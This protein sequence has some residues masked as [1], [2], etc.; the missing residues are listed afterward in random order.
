MNSS[1][2]KSVI[3]TLLL[4]GVA[5]PHATWAKQAQEDVRGA[6]TSAAPAAQREAI[7]SAA[8][9]T[10]RHITR[11]RSAI[12]NNDLDQA[13]QDVQQARELLSLVEAARPAA[14]LKE[15][16]WVVRQ[17]MDYE[18]AED[19]IDDLT[20]IDAE[21]LSL[22][23]IMPTA[24]AHRHLQ[25]VQTLM[26]KN[27]TE[28][29]RQELDRLEASLVFTEFDLPLA[30]C[31][32]QILAAQEAL[33]RN[34]PA[35]ADKNLVAA[36]ES[37]QF[38]TLGGG[39]ALV[40]A[41]THLRRA[42]KNYRDQYYAAAKADLAQ[43]SEWLRRA[44]KDTD[45]KG[46]KEAQELATKIDALKDKLDTE[47][48][49]HTHTLGNF[50]HRSAVLIQREAE[51][52][53]LRYKQ[54]RSANKTLRKLLDAKMHLFYAEYDLSLGRDTD[55]VRNEL[56]S[57]DR[58]LE[59]ALSEAGPPVRERINQLRKEVHALEEDLGG[60]REQAK[61]RYEQA[62]ADLIQLIHDH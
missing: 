57:T 11:A 8:L 10:L 59:E 48:D 6:V 27:N 39:T 9:R 5:V 47:A 23:D 16:L 2:L 18:T 36:E 3:A 29:A 54:Q 37:I 62:M 33:T 61:A 17:H 19:I 20:L 7:A 40:G 34:Q 28:A 22:G 50:L 21:L 51:D 60:D 44:G 13:R 24:K 58:Y 52:L 43:A 30:A 25:N 14:R 15:H 53:W 26:M 49:D 31:E 46:R 55:V 4:S 45:E 32:Q 41:R 38:I 12:H 42:T 1:I 35:A 56:E